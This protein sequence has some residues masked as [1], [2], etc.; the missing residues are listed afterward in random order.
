MILPGVIA[1]G[2]RPQAVGGGGGG[3]PYWTNVVSLLHFDGGLDDEKG[4]S[5]TAF[6]GAAPSAEKSKFGG[7]SL[8]LSDTGYVDG[9]VGA[10]ALPGSGDWVVEGWFYLPDAIG[11]RHLYAFDSNSSYIQLSGSSTVLATGNG[12]TYFWDS[13]PPMSERTWH[14]FALVSVGSNKYFYFNGTRVLTGLG[15]DYPF[16]S[17]TA[18]PRLGSRDGSTKS[19]FYMDEVRVTAGVSRY[20]ADFTPPT[21]PFPT[22]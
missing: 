14:H 7:S 12:Y 19:P 17:A 16:G 3:D 20:T 22:G 6:G 10:V 1:G 21:G 13:I 8:Y 4:G 18:R 9:P 5:W 2:R 15:A 11:T